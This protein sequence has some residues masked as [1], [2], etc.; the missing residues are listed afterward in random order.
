MRDSAEA[1]KTALGRVRA[2]VQ[3]GKYLTAASASTDFIKLSY[4]LECKP[5]L[6]LGEV[7]ENVY[8]QIN[9]ELELYSIPKQSQSDMKEKMTKHLDN[10]LAAYDRQEDLYGILVDIR[11]E[12][13]VF[14]F[15]VA[16]KHK[17]SQRVRPSRR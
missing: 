10:L 16:L 17:A 9:H 3:Q 4:H 1:L 13:T 5:E 12:A 7:L 2:A 8:L 11:Y 14:Q 15:E 6:F